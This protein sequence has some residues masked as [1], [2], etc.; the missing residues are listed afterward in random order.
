MFRR[1]EGGK[2]IGREKKREGVAKKDLRGKK[3]NK[4]FKKGAK[5]ILTM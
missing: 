5:K 1:G 3:G 2:K 4:W